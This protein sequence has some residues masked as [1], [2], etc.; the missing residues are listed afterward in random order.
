MLL[1]SNSNIHKIPNAAAGETLVSGTPFTREEE[2]LRA[3]R[4]TQA[5]F[6]ASAQRTLKHSAGTN[7]STGEEAQASTRARLSSTIA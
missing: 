5:E 7:G 4:R 6:A 1:S 2:H 3:P